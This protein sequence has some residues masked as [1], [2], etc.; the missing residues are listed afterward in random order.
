MKGENEDIYG[1]ESGLVSIIVPC[2]N[3]ANFLPR[4]LNSI[5]TQTYTYMQI[6]FVNDGSVDETEEVFCS[7]IPLFRDI[8]IRYRYIRQDN[9][10]QAEAV[11][12]ALPY[13]EGEYIMWVDADD[14]LAET[15]VGKK[16]ECL[17]DHKD[18]SIVCCKGVIV[19]EGNME[20][21]IG[22]LDNQHIVGEL[23]ENILFERAKCSCGLYMIRTLALFDV[24]PGKKIYPSRA[25]QNL[26]LLLP[27]SSKYK[28]CQMNEVLFYCVAR[29]DSHSHDI[30]GIQQWCKRFHDIKDI[31]LHVLHEMEGKLSGEYMSLLCRLVCLQETF[32]KI[33]MILNHDYEEEESVCVREEVQ[34]LY[35]HFA[36]WGK[37]R[38]YWIWGFCDKNRRLKQ[39]LEKYA[40]VT[41][42]GFID[43]DRTKWSGTDVVPPENIDVRKMYLIILL[44]DHPDISKRLHS[45]GFQTRQDFFYPE[46][47]ISENLKRSTGL[48]EERQR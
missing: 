18:V 28:T 10:G 8:G 41:V 20:C 4:L 46:F 7:Y 38:Q 13:V 45:C 24:L 39:Y 17:N 1:F 5:C 44:R 9:Q 15:H 40:G 25:G 14:Y 27:A 29:S 30:H 21:V 12:S 34:R 22:Y 48:R 2:C 36:D 42:A 11:N 47:E 26:Q 6:I 35:R 19:E 16:V 33:D 37:G 43:S 3:G 23:F 32:Q 31:K